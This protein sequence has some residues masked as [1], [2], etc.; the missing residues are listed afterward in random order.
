MIKLRIQA[1]LN[2][3]GKSRYWLAQQMGGM[4]YR[5]MTNLIDNKVSSIRFST[6]EKL[7]AVLDVQVS[8]LFEKIDE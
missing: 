8:D 6:L 7:C 4:C 2:E 5:N 3:K 1:I